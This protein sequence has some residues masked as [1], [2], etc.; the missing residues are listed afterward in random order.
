MPDIIHYGL[1]SWRT[2]CGR[3]L[4]VF[5]P[6]SS[7]TTYRDAVTCQR[8]RSTLQYRTSFFDNTDEP[9]TG[10][11]VTREGA[12]VPNTAESNPPP[13]EATETAEFY[14]TEARSALA[15]RLA[16]RNDYRGT[17]IDE[18]IRC[19]DALRSAEQR[20]RVVTNECEAMSYALD[21]MPVKP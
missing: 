18:V 10:R 3:M 8:C 9:V 15:E 14:L 5:T 12:I 2:A 20:L 11:P 6:E 4:T 13:T 21:V 16:E 1:P 19:Q 7:F 17:L